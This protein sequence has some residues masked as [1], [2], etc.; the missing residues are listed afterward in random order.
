MLR[1]ET[2]VI[3]NFRSEE[4]HNVILKE[5]SIFFTFS[6]TLLANKMKIIDVDIHHISWKTKNLSK[7]FHVECSMSWYQLIQAKRFFTI[8]LRFKNFSLSLRFNF[9]KNGIVR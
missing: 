5:N 4:W 3:H 2:V 7:Y 6:S 9:L 8:T 1:V